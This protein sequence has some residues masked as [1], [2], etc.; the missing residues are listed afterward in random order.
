MT[1]TI[2]A[3]LDCAVSDNCEYKRAGHC[4]CADCE[5]APEWCDFCIIMKRKQGQVVKEG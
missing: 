4:P 2:S 1:D 3:C 5:D